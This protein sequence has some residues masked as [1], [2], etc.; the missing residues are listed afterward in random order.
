MSHSPRIRFLAVVL[1]SL[2]LLPLF[3]VALA[4]RAK[5]DLSAFAYGRPL[6]FLI[7]AALVVGLALAP[8]RRLPFGLLF[9]LGPL[10]T[11]LAVIGPYAMFAN[12]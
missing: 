2:I 9:L 3:F 8:I 4:L 1:S 6:L 5:A 12:G 11:F 7:A 10:L